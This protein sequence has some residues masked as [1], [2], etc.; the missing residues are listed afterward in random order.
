MRKVDALAGMVANAARGGPWGEQAAG[1]WT[2][3]GYAASRFSNPS[4]RSSASVSL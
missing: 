4:M 3:G 1:A 2:A